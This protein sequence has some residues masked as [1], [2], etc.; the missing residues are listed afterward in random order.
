M[1]EDGFKAK[2]DIFAVLDN[3]DLIIRVI[4]NGVGMSDEKIG[5]ILTRE[6]VE[7]R[8]VGL[9][10]VDERIK[11]L[12]GENYGISI[13]SKEEIYTEVI[14]KFKKNLSDF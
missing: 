4:D 3:D 2:I 6:N 13:N 9:Y 12:Y 10:N 1:R 5:R 14:L 7:K 11:L 8:G